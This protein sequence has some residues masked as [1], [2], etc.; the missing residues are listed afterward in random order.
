MTQANGN[1]S[2]PFACPIC[3][4]TLDENTGAL[5]CRQ[6]E[7]SFEM[8]DGIPVFT[9]NRE[10]YFTFVAKE[11]VEKVLSETVTRG[12][13]ETMREVHRDYPEAMHTL[14]RRTSD[15]ARGAGKFLLSLGPQS[16]V[17]DI[18]CGMGALSFSFARSCGQVVSL[19][20][21]LEYLRWIKLYAAEIGL[22]NI[23][24]VCAGDEAHL[25]F[26]DASF[27]AV[28]LSGVWEYMALARAGEPTAVQLEYLRD[29]SRVLR[30]QGQVYIGIENRLSWRYFRGRPEEHTKMRFAA[31]MPR[32]LS[33]FIYKK[34]FGREFRIYTYSMRGYRHWLKEAGFEHAEFY[35]PL[36]EYSNIG[37]LLPLDEA[38][39]SSL[40]PAARFSPRQLREQSQS[41]TLGRNFA[42]SFVIIGDKGKRGE[43]MLQGLIAAA[44][45]T[46]LDPKLTTERWNLERF[47]VRRKTRKLHLHLRA[48]NGQAILGKVALDATNQNS[49][50]T[51]YEVLEHLWESSTLSES[52]KN[53]LPRL[54]GRAQFGTHEIC[55]E[56]WRPG[57]ELRRSGALK[58]QLAEEARQFLFELQQGTRVLRVVEAGL[59]E[60]TFEAPLRMLRQWFTP[61]ELPQ[62][63]SRI[64]GIESYCR[65]ALQGKTLPFVAR[66]GDFGMTNVLYNR[67][68]QHISIVVDWDSA[69]MQGLPLL[70]LMRFEI[71][72]DQ[73]SRSIPRD[74]ILE[75]GLRGYADLLFDKGFRARFDESLQS[76]QMD[77][78]FFLPIA[79]VYWAAFVNPHY[80][81]ARCRWN[82]EWSRVNVAEVLEILARQLDL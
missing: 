57:F 23:V 26:P 46:C 10:Q 64:V 53:L 69:M 51:N 35:Y 63:E 36:P 12:W 78:Q 8:V 56:E 75:H 48:A 25:P 40:A 38:S 82:P 24:P 34:K 76:L 39:R 14:F 32:Q 73:R 58:N 59:Y 77:E 70:D 41:S 52:V 5:H 20:S 68:T 45:D 15:E 3:T 61:Q 2:L 71:Q 62:W 30:P 6:C 4:S 16:R 19:D 43:S 67:Q 47:E 7:K 18:G 33:N 21:T 37:K 72:M 9:R 11:V 22:N 42:R 31:L 49:T 74:S 44:H 54:F 17:L 79:F 13:D 1:S 81:I 55:L 66:H 50:S 27:D 65:E 60:D 80:A 28:V 29:V